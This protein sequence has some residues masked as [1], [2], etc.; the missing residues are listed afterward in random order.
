MSTHETGKDQHVHFD[1]QGNIEIEEKEPST[2]GRLHEKTQ[3]GHE[4][5][6]ENLN[7]QKSKLVKL[8]KRI[9]ADIF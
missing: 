9:N 7:K 2:S 8:E 1:N 5:Y 6:L 4:L 3:K